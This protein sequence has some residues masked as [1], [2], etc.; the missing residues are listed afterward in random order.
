MGFFEGV[1]MLVRKGFVDIPATEIWKRFE[2]IVFT[3]RVNKKWP[4]LFTNYKYLKNL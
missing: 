2:D 1:G 3:S 4:Q